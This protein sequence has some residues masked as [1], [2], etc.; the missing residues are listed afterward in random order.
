MESIYK[1]MNAINDKESLNEKYNVKDIQSV[2]KLN[3]DYFDEPSEEHEER[4]AD[5]YSRAEEE[6]EKYFN[7]TGAF[8]EPSTQCGRGGV[9]L[10]ADDMSF[11]GS[12][13]YETSEQYIEDNDFEGFL[14]LFIDAFTP[15]TDGDM[16]EDFETDG[17]VMTDYGFESGENDMNDLYFYKED[18]EDVVVTVHGNDA[19]EG[20]KCPD[21]GKVIKR[22]TK[23]TLTDGDE[24]T[25]LGSVMAEYEMSSYGNYYVLNDARIEDKVWKVLNNHLKAS[26]E[27]NEGCEVNEEVSPEMKKLQDAAA[28]VKCKLTPGFI[29]YATEDP[30]M[31]DNAIEDEL[32]YCG[33]ALCNEFPDMIGW[34]F[35]EDDELTDKY[36]GYCVV[37]TGTDE[38]KIL[39]QIDGHGRIYNLE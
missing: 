33:E 3:E 10:F 34:E 16:D 2:K 32:L 1:Q 29:E 11:D 39:V 28:S 12:V 26:R 37:D 22:P 4:A 7:C 15:E 36:G 35:G 25:V 5:F 17:S 30:D 31:L 9:F 13:D 20:V 24:E 38:G 8:L 18:S 19:V 21:A 14:Q 27:Q 23:V 6:L